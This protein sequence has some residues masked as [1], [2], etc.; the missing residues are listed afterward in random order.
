M[1]QRTLF[2]KDL[3]LV[4]LFRLKYKLKI[5]EACFS[6]GWIPNHIILDKTRNIHSYCVFFF[7]DD[8]TFTNNFINKDLIELSRIKYS[9][10]DRPLFIF[11]ISGDLSIKFFEIDEF[12]N[13]LE[14]KELNELNLERLWI[15]FDS[16]FSKI[17]SEL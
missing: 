2:D 16:M 10:L 3:D 5:E 9:S 12:K 4:T 17:K 15:D 11:K 8:F 6:R 7:Q 1:P 13:L 14:Q